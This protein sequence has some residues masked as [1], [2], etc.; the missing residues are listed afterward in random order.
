MIALTSSKL[1]WHHQ[2]SD[3][4]NHGARPWTTAPG[5]TNWRA[6]SDCDLNGKLQASCPRSLV[7]G[8]GSVTAGTGTRRGSS[9]QPSLSGPARRTNPPQWSWRLPQKT[10]L[11]V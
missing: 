1:P 6:A 3:L 7:A 9:D 4:G 8:E 10:G 2:L 5:W 11:P